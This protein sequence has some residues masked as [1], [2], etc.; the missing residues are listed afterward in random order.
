MRGQWGVEG[1][2]DPLPRA[3][4]R[5]GEGKGPSPSLD[6]GPTVGPDAHQLFHARGGQERRPQELAAE[7]ADAV[8]SQQDEFLVDSDPGLMAGGQMS[9]GENALALL[10]PRFNTGARRP[11]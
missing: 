1:E 9:A 8:L 7:P 10:G 11:R 5:E 4:S 3:V 6:G 2:G